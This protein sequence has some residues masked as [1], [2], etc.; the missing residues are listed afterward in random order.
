MRRFRNESHYNFVFH[1]EME[2][3]L[4]EPRTNGA[5]T[6]HVRGQQLDMLIEDRSSPVTLVVFHS[7]LTERK[8]TIPVLE[9][10]GMAES[11]GVNLVAIADPSLALGDIDLAWYLGNRWLG[12]LREHMVPMIDHALKSLGTDRVILFG[13]SGGGYA[14]ASFAPYFPNCIAL[15]INPQLN[16]AA[17]PRS[18]MATYLRVCHKAQTTTPMKRIRKQFVTDNVADIIGNKL[19]FDMLVFQ[20][21]GD[22]SYLRYQTMPFVERY[23]QDWR[24]GVRFMDYGRG[25][26]PIPKPYLTQM[27]AGLTAPI[28]RRQAI[29][30]AGFRAYRPETVS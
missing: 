27:L 14:A 5:H 4:S 16:L 20:N 10:R 7:L 12:P 15:V 11:S 9:G 28:S 8:P 24:L 18:Q 23:K 19:D 25:H 30:D 21:L 1:G 29:R 6:V 2:G 3:F 26:R 17:S 13:A 22:S